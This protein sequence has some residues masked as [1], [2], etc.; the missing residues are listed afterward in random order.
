MLVQVRCMFATQPNSFLT[1]SQSCIVSSD[2]EPPAPQVKSVKRGPSSFMRRIRFFRFS[3]PESV[4]GGKYSK[5]NQGFFCS[6]IN[7]HTLLSLA[8]VD[9]I[10]AQIL[11]LSDSSPSTD[12]VE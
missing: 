11:F 2:V 6:A 7:S 5:E 1:V 4:F 10:A 12:T 9:T 3:T 8:P